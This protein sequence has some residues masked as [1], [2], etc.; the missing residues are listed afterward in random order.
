MV[1]PAVLRASCFIR[2]IC[3]RLLLEAR[4]SFVPT[5]FSVWS[6]LVAME[7]IPYTDYFFHRPGGSGLISYYTILPLSH[8]L[9]WKMR[10]G[11]STY[12]PPGGAFCATQQSPDW[13]GI[14]TPAWAGLSSWICR[15]TGSG[16]WFPVI[17]V[18][19]AALQFASR[20]FFP[21]THR[22]WL[23]DPNPAVWPH[24]Q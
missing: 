15:G 21:R 13:N 23:V 18:S 11:N 24:L 10:I 6:V 14:A 17:P 8:Q 1:T 3:V 12:M 9:V 5:V 19:A 7:S 16:F 22:L 4:L 20:L 2:R